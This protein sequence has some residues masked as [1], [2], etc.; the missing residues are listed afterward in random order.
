MSSNQNYLKKVK[1]VNPFQPEQE[2]VDEAKGILKTGGL[3]VFPT[4]GLYGLAA[5]PLNTA[6]VEKI[7][8]LKRRSPTKAILLL[9]PSRESIKRF[10]PEIPREADCLMKAIWP[11]RLTIVFKANKG[12]PANLTAKTG[13][14]GLRVPEHPVARALVNRFGPITGTSA[15][16]SEKN[17]CASVSEMPAELIEGVDLVLDAGKLEGGTGSTV[18]D[19]SDD[20]LRIL[21]A[22]AVKIWEIEKILYGNKHRCVDNLPEISYI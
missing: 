13:K 18:I 17:G 10:T 15:N 20:N 2:I 4:R 21:R 9:I 16:L 3:V 5:D 14:I 7:Y 12:I 1:T 6:A 11:G 22:G 19:V 8:A